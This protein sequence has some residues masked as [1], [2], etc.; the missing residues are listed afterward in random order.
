MQITNRSPLYVQLGFK[1]LV[2]FFLCYFIW[3]AQ[4]ILVPFAFAILLAVLLLPLVSFLERRKISRVLSI[5]I[6]LFVAIVFLGIIIYFLSTQIAIFVDDIPSIKKH[7]NDHWITVQKWI[8]A[9]LN[10][11]LREQNEYFNDAAENI[12]GTKG[13]YIS[14]TFFSITEALML[15][16]LL[17]IYTF[18]ILY[19]RD[20]IR[21]FLYAVFRKEYSEKVTTVITQSKLMINSYMT[22]LLI[23]MGIVAVCNSIGLLMLGIKYALF[24]GVMAAVLN[25]IP[26]IGMFTATLFTVLVTLTTSDNTSDIIWVIVVMYGIHMLD[27]NILMPKII[28]SRLR[29]NAL[30]SILGV[31]IGGALTGISGLFLSVPAVAMVKIICDQI[32]GMEPWGMLM[33]DDITYAKRGRLYER[34]KALRNRKIGKVVKTG[35]P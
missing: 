18:L 31:I 29:I 30:I 35:S 13:E 16:I 7:L 9:K 33:G 2:L 11:S 17:P 26:Y 6:A 15:I 25:I 3:V 32:E 20:L 23:E 12:T 34:I 28:S 24:F 14:D 21:S 8:K 27:V 22:G 5:A 10:I 4:E 19:Y 1:F